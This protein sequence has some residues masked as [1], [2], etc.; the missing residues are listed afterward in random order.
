[1]N[2]EL[3]N[4]YYNKM[5]EYSKETNNTN[6][7]EIYEGNIKSLLSSISKTSVVAYLLLGPMIDIKNTDLVKRVDEDLFY[8]VRNIEE[9]K[10]KPTILKNGNLRCNRFTISITLS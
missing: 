3:I 6:Y 1:M 9:R 2:E 5:H 4:N 8:E 10:M 7:I